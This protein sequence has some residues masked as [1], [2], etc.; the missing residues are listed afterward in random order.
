LVTHY[1]SIQIVQMN[2]HSDVSYINGF[3]S[4]IEIEGTKSQKKKIRFSVRD[5]LIE[6]GFNSIE[7]VQYLTENTLENIGIDKSLHFSIMEQIQ[8]VKKSRSTN[9]V[10]FKLA[11]A[12]TPASLIAVPIVSPI[13]KRSFLPEA[14]KLIQ[15][16][17]EQH[18]KKLLA[19]YISPILLEQQFAQ[20]GPDLETIVYAGI[21]RDALEICRM[22]FRHPKYDTIYEWKKLTL[23]DFV[24]NGLSIEI[25]K[26]LHT[27]IQS[28]PLVK[29]LT[30]LGYMQLILGYLRDGVTT[31][32]FLEILEIN[33]FCY[34]ETARLLS[35]CILEKLEIEGKH[36]GKILDNIKK[37]SMRAHNPSRGFIY[38]LLA[39]MDDDPTIHKTYVQRF[40]DR[41][42]IYPEDLVHLEHDSHIEEWCPVGCYLVLCD[43]LKHVW[44]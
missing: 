41:G 26:I 40:H 18:K 9:S 28:I 13:P 21:H 33:M 4:H 24:R 31:I 5:R 30:R 25:G 37:V 43:I 42:Y 10:P 8:R 27:N 19:T 32:H 35:P 14:L 44:A 39:F 7:T 11:P 38:R 29:S 15:P 20:M 34:T 23:D 6:N 1:A 36:R 22:I 12:P 3:L 16:C 17:I 2:Y